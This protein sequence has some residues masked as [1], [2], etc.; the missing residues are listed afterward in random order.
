VGG[1]PEL[2]DGEYRALA[3][4]RYQI[5]R[6][7]HFSEEAA[8]GESLEPQQHQ[9]M[10]AIRGLEGGDCPTVGALAEY[11]FIRHHSAVGLIDRLEKRGMVIRAR[12]SDDR[13]HA[14]VRLTSEGAAALERLSGA[15]RA[16]LANLAPRLVAALEKALARH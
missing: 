8:R 13:R 7:L 15:H 16:E 9:M 6:F 5:R 4:F 11:L 10:L 12:R 1:Q 3:D 2:N 14:T